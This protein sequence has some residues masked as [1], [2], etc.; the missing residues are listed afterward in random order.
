MVGV[1]VY[2]ASSI[3]LLCIKK[4]DH[5]THRHKGTAIVW[6]TWIEQLCFACFSTVMEKPGKLSGP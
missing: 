1:W 2:D 4:N 5:Y 3:R 6:N